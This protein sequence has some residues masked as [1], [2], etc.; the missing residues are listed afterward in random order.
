[1]GGSSGKDDEGPKGPSLLGGSGGMLSS[2][3][4]IVILAGCCPS[5]AEICDICSDLDR[6]SQCL[7]A[8][9]LRLI[10]NRKSE[11]F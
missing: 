1:M 10:S 5:A 4:W 7:N 9:L 11:T 8:Q 2:I 6:L 3:V